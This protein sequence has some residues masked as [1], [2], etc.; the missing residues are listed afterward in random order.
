[1]AEEMKRLMVGETKETKEMKRD[2]MM[3]KKDSLMKKR[4]SLLWKIFE[5]EIVLLGY[6]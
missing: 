6:C 5:R 3:E 1:M 2:L 4:K